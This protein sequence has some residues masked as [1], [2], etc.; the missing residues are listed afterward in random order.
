MVRQSEIFDRKRLLAYSKRK[1]PEPEGHAY[2]LVSINDLRD[3]WLHP[4]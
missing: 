1:L 4:E 2:N 3:E